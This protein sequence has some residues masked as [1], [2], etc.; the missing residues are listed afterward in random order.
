[1]IRPLC[2]IFFILVCSS[3]YSQGQSKLDSLLEAL[4]STPKGQAKIDLYEKICWYHIDATGDLVQAKNFAD[5]VKLLAA[6]VKSEKGYFQSE[7]NY[8]MI[9]HF[10]GRYSEA[11]EHL[12]LFTAYFKAEGDSTQVAKGL[13]HIA[14]VH[15]NQGNYDRT[16]AMLYRVLAIEEKVNNKKKIAHVLNVIGATYKNANKL[17][18][19]LTAYRQATRIFKAA[20]LN[21][22]YA[23]GLVNM[24]NIFIDMKHYDSARLGYGE[25]L[26]IFRNFNNPVLIGMTL[27]NLGNLYEAQDQYGKALEYHQ[28]AL[29]IW[30]T[31]TRQSSLANSLNNNGKSFLK[32]K[33]YGEAETY[34]KEALTIAQKIKANPL[35]VEIYSNIN[36]MH[37]EKKEYEKAYHFYSLSNQIKDSLF[38]EKNAKQINELQA[39]Y[40]TEKKDKQIVLLAKEKEL[41]VKETERQATLNKAF[42]I[43][44][45]LLI[46]VAG[47]LFYIYRQRSLLREKTTE[48]KEA[49]FKRQASELEMKAL[50]AQI[51]PHFLFNC[52]NAINLMIRKGETENACL[53]LAK[54]SKLVRLI[55]ENA[56]AS[57]VTLESEI[58]LMESY[59][60]LE[61]LRFP[62][63]IEYKV[64]I[65]KSIG[66]QNTYLPSMVLQPVI[67]NAIW[68]GIVHKDNG[69]NGIIT[70]DVMQEED[71]L[72][73]TVE[74]NGVGRDKAKEL[75]DRSV[76]NNKSMG[77]K[78]TE[79]RLRLLSRKQMDHFIEI[80]DLK[81]AANH[82]VGTRVTIHI[83]I[84][85]Q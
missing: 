68:H 57:F 49:D 33:K 25:S 73:C 71:R 51:N 20:N 14:M 36:A 53:Y 62:R 39:K 80:T 61:E 11:L 31:N 59:V 74:D 35:L 48:I 7:Y 3:V 46:L 45:G 17:P 40:E 66:V 75:R 63:K 60:Q 8:G 50:R 6:E 42:A 47:L 54:F 15:M 77:M 29:A 18:E 34:L 72:L 55:L 19:A 5:S 83:P 41:Q 21:T 1:M 78:I 28:Q 56:E 16:L 26:E 9:A 12:G 76:L 44:L 27:G 24:A 84:A 85:E 67:E 52:M 37:L 65:D 10:Q 32:L 58:A 23:M 30:R 81:D 82:A 43:G 2:T 13:Y 79:E 69:E 4:K 64:S 70:V 22:D 38:N